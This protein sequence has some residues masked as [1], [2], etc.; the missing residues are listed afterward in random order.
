MF[1]NPPD[2]NEKEL[3]RIFEEKLYV[4]KKHPLADVSNIQMK[5]IGKSD[6]HH[7]DFIKGFEDRR[8]FGGK[9]QSINSM[10]DNNSI[11]LKETTT[12]YDEVDKE[13][14]DEISHDRYILSGL[15]KETALEGIYED[16]ELR[17]VLKT[18]EMLMSNEIKGINHNANKPERKVSFDTHAD[19]IDI[20]SDVTPEN[21]ANVVGNAVDVNDKDRVASINSLA[22]KTNKID[23]IHRLEKEFQNMIQ[24]HKDTLKVKSKVYKFIYNEIYTL[25]SELSRKVDSLERENACLGE[26]I[27]ELE[28]EREHLK[29]EI[30]DLKGKIEK[31]KECFRSYNTKVTEKAMLWKGM[32]ES[33]VKEYLKKIN[34]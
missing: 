3:E 7:T 16:L 8:I 30:V 6:F 28:T 2:E 18:K 31:F 13:N 33:K 19:V 5:G 34:K 12:A 29:D 10:K 24:T 14:A 20:C 26:K 1:S 9:P 32:I 11:V 22:D 21:K 4:G 15:P 25:R 27:K 23:K 17:D